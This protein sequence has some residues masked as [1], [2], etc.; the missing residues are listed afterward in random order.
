MSLQERSVCAITVGSI[1]E[2]L[3]K[4]LFKIVFTCLALWFGLLAASAD[5]LQDCANLSG[6]ARLAACELAIQEN[7]S[8]ADAYVA[9][10][11]YHRERGDFGKAITDYDKALGIKPGALLAQLGRGLAYCENGDRGRGLADLNGAIEADQKSA[12]AYLYRGRCLDGNGDTIH[13]IDD[14]S[15]AIEINSQM[16]E[17]YIDRASAFAKLGIHDRSIADSSKAIDMNPRLA[18]P[19]LNR[20]ISQ[21]AKGAF[22][23][24]IGDLNIAIGI[25]PN[26]SLAYSTRGSVYVKRKIV[27]DRE[28]AIADFEQALL[29]NPADKATKAI[30]DILNPP[31]QL[32]TGPDPEVLEGCS[33]AKDRV[34]YEFCMTMGGARDRAPSKQPG[35]SGPGR[36]LIQ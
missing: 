23:V 13:A 21:I 3:Q 2:F 26:N 16:V 27:G 25:E 32:T 14:F 11:D 12:M 19:H 17:A 22:D 6:D 5:P 18:R 1:Y 35:S 29:I 36:L 15:A 34:M 7:S 8:N 9:R 28:R 20:A 10:A 30:L 31:E 4:F 24:A 33:R